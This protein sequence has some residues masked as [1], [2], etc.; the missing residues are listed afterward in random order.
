MLLGN[1]VQFAEASIAHIWD[2][3]KK[4]CGWNWCFDC[5]CQCCRTCGPIFAICVK[6]KII[7]L[8]LFSH[9]ALNLFK[10]LKYMV[11][12][13]EYNNDEFW[14]LHLSLRVQTVHLQEWFFRWPVVSKGLALDST[15]IGGL[16]LSIWLK[17]SDFCLWCSFL[18][19]CP[20]AADSLSFS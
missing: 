11:L 19:S 6:N 20:V 4:H 18:I 2:L 13:I 10:V 8:H 17:L 5:I 1:E 14:L 3:I 9:G 15:G 12:D 16:K 7:V